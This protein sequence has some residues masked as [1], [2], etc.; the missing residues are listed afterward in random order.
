MTNR[1]C[2][3]ALSSVLLFAASPARSQ[4]ESS[5][6]K[7][8]SSAVVDIGI[9]VRDLEKSA[10]F[11][12]DVLGL[13][14]VKGFS[15]PAE[16]TTEFGLTDN[17]PATVRVFVLEESAKPGTKL[18]IMSFPEAPGA[19]QDQQFIH[20]TLGVSY[21]TFFV[22]DMDAAVARLAKAKVKLLGKTPAPLGGPSRITVFRDPDGNFIEL[23]GP[24]KK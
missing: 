9:V 6:A 4:N 14:E 13:T 8:F 20:S 12:R 19:K 16:K 3:L 22:T 21:L 10:T 1:R 15:V 11:Y 18:K 17:Q 7:T 23:I 2:A 24:S 5:P